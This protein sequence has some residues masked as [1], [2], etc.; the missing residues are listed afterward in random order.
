[1]SIWCIRGQNCSG[2]KLSSILPQKPCRIRFSK[3]NVFGLN[4]LLSRTSP[5]LL[6][7]QTKWRDWGQKCLEVKFRSSLKT[8]FRLEFVDETCPI[9]LSS[10]LRFVQTLYRWKLDVESFPKICCMTHFEY[11]KAS[12]T[13]LKNWVT[14]GYACENRGGFGGGLAWRIR[15]PCG[16]CTARAASSHAS[17]HDAARGVHASL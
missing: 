3:K 2:R 8:R 7:K 15:P 14:K 13:A 12:K 5:I 1:M 17:W 9:T 10:K 6:A 11:Q 4:F 16:S